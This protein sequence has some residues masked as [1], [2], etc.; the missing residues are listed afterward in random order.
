MLGSPFPLLSCAVLARVLELDA[1]RTC[2]LVYFFFRV[3][4]VRCRRYP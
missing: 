1:C 3:V 4:V 2:L